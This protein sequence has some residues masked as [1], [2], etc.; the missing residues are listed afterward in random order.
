[1]LRCLI[2]TPYEQNGVDLSDYGF[3]LS[4]R[5]QV[6][7][8]TY[9]THNFG[10]DVRD[11]EHIKKLGLNDKEINF[12]F[13]ALEDTNVKPK[14][15]RV[16]A[17]LMDATEIILSD[18]SLVFT[19]KETR[20]GSINN[21]HETYVDFTAQ[22][23][24]SGYE[25]SLYSK[26]L[27]MQAFKNYGLANVGTYKTWP[28]FV[29]KFNSDCGYVSFA[30]PQGLM[31][32]GNFGQQ[33]KVYVGDSELL[34]NE[35][36]DPSTGGIASWSYANLDP[37]IFHR[38]AGAFGGLF[39]TGEFG[40]KL[41]QT[42]TEVEKDDKG[43]EIGMP[44]YDN[45]A[46]I[47]K[48]FNKDAA[49]DDTAQNFVL[50]SRLRFEE[51][52]STETELDAQGGAIVIGVMD[53]DQV[54][55][56]FMTIL[57]VNVGPTNAQIN[58][59]G[60]STEKDERISLGWWADK[61]HEHASRN[62]Y[63]AIKI[64]KKGNVFT[65]DVHNTRNDSAAGKDFSVSYTNNEMAQ[66]NAKYGFIYMG[67]RNG[68]DLRQYMEV[69]AFKLTKLH[70]ASTVDIR[71]PFMQGDVLEIDHEEGTIKLNDF[72]YN[73]T[74]AIGSRFWWLEPGVN[75]I[76]VDHSEWATPPDILMSYR[77]NWR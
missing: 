34:L 18:E 61:N 65:F 68:Q 5:P 63:G 38:F 41:I 25:K 7:V 53:E 20:I 55:L 56:V 6:I 19:V 73:D 28:K 2:R 51:P 1:M 33:D 44:R 71:N 35:E 77:E 23:T 66:R 9:K 14:L 47:V 48:K 70:S 16:I 76:R 11:G 8:S 27:A 31:Q 72:P 43:R 15:R 3:C 12:N 13:N 50:E 69:T 75:E 46:T 45:S 37:L 22:F 26:Q 67:Q 10:I 59:A 52:K 32:I 57:D 39:E 21:E 62:L 17:L 54:P 4:E 74:V 36:L 30:S 58:F 64:T 24:V 42:E 49:E 29:T 60:Y 40:M